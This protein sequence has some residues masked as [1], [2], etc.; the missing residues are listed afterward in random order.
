MNVGIPL[1]CFF[2]WKYEQ[3]VSAR[4]ALEGGGISFVFL[5][6]F[7]LLMWRKQKKSTR[8]VETQTRKKPDT[9]RMIWLIVWIIAALWA[10]AEPTVH[11]RRVGDTSESGTVAL[12][13]VTIVGCV[14][15]IRDRRK[16]SAK[17]SK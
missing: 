6:L 2:F 14:I 9:I 8:G 4:M 15:L 16:K 3:G 11:H 10:I 12:L 5:N 13:I 17:N 1:W 7:F